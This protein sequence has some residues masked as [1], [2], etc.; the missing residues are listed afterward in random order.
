MNH[1]APLS[2][3]NN[4]DNDEFVRQS[5]DALDRLWESIQKRDLPSDPPLG[6]SSPHGPEERGCGD[7]VQS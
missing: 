6:D 5:Q 3:Q 1:S 7:L 4:C 2:K